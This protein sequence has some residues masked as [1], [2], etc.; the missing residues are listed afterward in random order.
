LLFQDSGG[1][2]LMARF[3]E[4]D[5]FVISGMTDSTST[6]S[7]DPEFR[8]SPPQLQQ[9]QQEQLIEPPICVKRQHNAPNMA[10]SFTGVSWSEDFDQHP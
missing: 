2:S 6:E 10:E 5:P 3:E 9:Q 8:S 4:E 1:E 7:D